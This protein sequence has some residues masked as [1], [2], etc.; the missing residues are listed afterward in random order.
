MRKFILAGAMTAA[1]AAP[2]FA[3][4]TIVEERYYVIQD[5]ATKRC[6]YVTERPS[7]GVVLELGIFRTRAEADL[8]ARKSKVC[9]YDD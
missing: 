5:P 7:T 6:T 8:G 2:A 1:I 9:V 3:Q 4:T